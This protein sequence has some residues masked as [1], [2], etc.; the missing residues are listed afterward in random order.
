M[1]FMCVHSNGPVG[2]STITKSARRCETL[3]VMCLNRIFVFYVL[4]YRVVH[5]YFYF[6]VW[7]RTCVPRINEKNP[8]LDVSNLWPY[9]KW[10]TVVSHAK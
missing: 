2:N 9:Y 6:P 10:V 3:N 8:E 7:H 5:V 4:I 1:N